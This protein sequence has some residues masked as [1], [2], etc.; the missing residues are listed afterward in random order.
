M[1]SP[2]IAPVSTV[3]V[4]IVLAIAASSPADADETPNVTFRQSSTA[5]DAYD[6]VECIVPHPHDPQVIYL[7]CQYGL[8]PSSN[9]GETRRRTTNEMP[10]HHVRRVAIR[11]SQPDVMSA[12]L[13]TSPVGRP[14]KAASTSRSTGASVGSHVW[15]DWLSTQASLAKPASGRSIATVRLCIPRIPTSA[16]TDGGNGVLVGEVPP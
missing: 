4:F 10:H 11:T 14:G 15:K 3:A 8:Y 16:A 5:V 2:L 12:T 1:K 9:A 6:F 13:W 7:G